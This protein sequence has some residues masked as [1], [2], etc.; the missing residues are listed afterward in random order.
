MFDV[1]AAADKV[2]SE[3]REKVNNGG[4][5]DK[6]EIV[7]LVDGAY[8]L[9]CTLSAPNTVSDLKCKISQLLVECQRYEILS[10]QEFR[11]M[12]SKVEIAESNALT[13]MRMPMSV[14]ILIAHLMYYNTL[15]CLSYDSLNELQAMATLF[16]VPALLQAYA[17]EDSFK[18]YVYEMIRIAYDSS[19]KGSISSNKNLR[20]ALRLGALAGLYNSSDE[21]EL[22]AIV[23]D[24]SLFLTACKERIFSEPQLE[25]TAVFGGN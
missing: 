25:N 13:D 7:K 19:D 20:M 18:R 9:F 4:P 24:E 10:D 8:L 23:G 2:I 16:S 15:K 12:Y 1:Y 17:T 3:L 6:S 21:N 11:S 14:A 5:I 22:I